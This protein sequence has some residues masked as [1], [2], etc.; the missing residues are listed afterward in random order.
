MTTIELDEVFQYH[1]KTTAPAAS[2][3]LIAQTEKEFGALLNLHALFAEAPVTYQTYMTAFDQFLKQSSFSPLEA[4]VVFMTANFHNRCHY[5][6]AGHTMMMKMGKMPDDVIEDLREGRPLK[7]PKLRA[8]QRFSR[9]L[10]EARGHVGDVRLQAFFD[11][12]YDRKAALEVLTGLA[13]K[14]ISNFTNALAHTRLDRGMDK[15][16]WVHPDER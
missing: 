12:G 5:C 13:A 10:L 14:L 3:P 8:L 11:A 9:Q 7:D 15:F 16:A 1:T 6:M 4:Q 2:Q